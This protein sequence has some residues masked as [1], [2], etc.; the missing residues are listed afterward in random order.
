ME[1]VN[2]GMMV[3]WEWLIRPGQDRI[4]RGGG[5]LC[6]EREREKR[7]KKKGEVVPK[8]YQK[9]N[10]K[11]IRINPNRPRRGRKS[12]KKSIKNWSKINLGGVPGGLWKILAA[13]AE[14]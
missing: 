14:K 7:R 6:R 5:G 10:P 11:S 9:G 8:I 1:R 12:I 4:G 3:V 13:N 2:D